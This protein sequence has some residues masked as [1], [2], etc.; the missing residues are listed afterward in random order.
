VANL[1][2]KWKGKHQER[3]GTYINANTIDKEEH[4]GCGDAHTQACRVC[5]FLGERAHH[6]SFQ[7]QADAA[8]NK[9]SHEEWF[10][11]N[12]VYHDCTYEVTQYASRDPTA[13]KD[14]L[15]RRIIS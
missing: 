15:M 14:E 7:D 13:L 8:P 9:T 12:S 1:R 4:I 2:Q 10:P 11:T 6:R 3:I 5:S